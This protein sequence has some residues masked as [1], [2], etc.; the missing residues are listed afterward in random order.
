MGVSDIF[1]GIAEAGYAI[2][3]APAM[4]QEIWHNAPFATM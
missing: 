3:T 2:S 1:E 4:P